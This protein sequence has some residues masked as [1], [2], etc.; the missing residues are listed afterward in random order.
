MKII[1][2]SKGSLLAD[3]ALVAKTLVQR[4]TGLLDRDRLEQGEA[5]IIKPCS[6][7]H[8]FFMRFPIDVLFVSNNLRVIRAI[9]YMP[10]FRL[11]PIIF[12]ADFAIE[13]PAGVISRSSTGKGDL[14]E[15]AFLK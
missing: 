11:S 1:N 12:R 7:I 13:L 15:I 14:L 10:P 5:L 3:R 4:L 8:T 9:E 2:F 6:S